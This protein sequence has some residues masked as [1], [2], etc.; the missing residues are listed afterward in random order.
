MPRQLTAAQR[1]ALDAMM[2]GQPDLLDSVRTYTLLFL[3][4]SL[5]GAWTPVQT[6]VE[7]AAGLTAAERLG[8]IL[9][10]MDGQEHLQVVLWYRNPLFEDTRGGP[11]VA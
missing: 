2:A 7:P 8:R 9:M 11:Q 5:S 1:A 6:V 10:Q 4:R 3:A